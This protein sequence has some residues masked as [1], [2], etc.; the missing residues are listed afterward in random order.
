MVDIETLGTNSGSVITWIAGVFFDL[1]TGDKGECFSQAVNIKSNM[2][3]GLTINSSTALWWMRQEEALEAWAKEDK[4]SLGT[5]LDLF[6]EFIDL[7]LEEFEIWGNSNR[8]D[9]GILENAYHALGRKIPWK[10]QNE[11]DVRTLVSFAPEIK[12]RVLARAKDDQELFHDPL[13][14]CSIQIKY[15]SDIYSKLSK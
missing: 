7:N 3:A 1:G 15:C 6:D 13:V 2:D 12:E 14:D 8:F 10:F 9:M 5:A 11:R 4:V